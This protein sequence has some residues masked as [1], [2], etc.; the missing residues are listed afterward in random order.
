MALYRCT[1]KRFAT[2]T[3]A[4]SGAQEVTVNIGFKPKYLTI[5]ADSTT[6]KMMNIYNSDISTTK[7]M[8]AWGS[9]YGGWVN[10]GDASNYTIQ[11]ITNTGF[12]VRGAS[13]SS[14]GFA[15]YAIG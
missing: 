9:A 14:T 2:G 6:N 8:R 4:Y 15:Y 7:F 5:S 11:S 12:S 1:G 3:S 10:I 13:G